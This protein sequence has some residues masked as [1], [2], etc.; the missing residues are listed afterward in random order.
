MLGA[1]A[2]RLGRR[3][4]IRRLFAVVLGLV[5]A[6][7]TAPMGAAAYTIA[8]LAS[9][10][11]NC[12]QGI[13]G[14][15]AQGDVVGLGDFASLPF[16]SEPTLGRD[17]FF[18]HDGAFTPLKVLSGG[19]TSANHITG[20]GT[21]GY[22]TANAVN[23]SGL[24]VGT[25]INRTAFPSP[26]LA[27]QWSGSG[28]SPVSLGT[29]CVPNSMQFQGSAA[30]A[31]NSAG[32]VAGQSDTQVA[33][34]G[35]YSGIRPSAGVLRRA[36]DSQ[37]SQ[38]AVAGSPVSGG[39][40]LQDGTIYGQA[41]NAHDQ[42]VVLDDN[43][44]AASATLPSA[45]LWTPTTPGGPLPGTLTAL[46]IFP[47]ALSPLGPAPPNTAP[48]NSSSMVLNDAGVV[49]GG[50]LSQVTGYTPAYSQNGGSA[51]SLT[52]ADGLPFGI[53]SAI[54]NHG[55][56]VGTSFNTSGQ[57]VATLWSG[58]GSAPGSTGTDLNTLLPKNSGWALSEG[59]GIGDGGDIVAYGSLNG[60]PGEYVELQTTGR[61][62]IQGTI[63]D[64]NGKGLPNVT[65]KLTGTDST[66]GSTVNTTAVTDATGSYL[67]QLNTGDYTV[68][69]QPPGRGRFLDV[70]CDGARTPGA[71]EV[72][73][74]AKQQAT[75]SFKY[76][77]GIVVNSTADSHNGQSSG[78]QGACDATPTEPK[79][80][81]TLRAAIE[82]SNQLGGRNIT[83]DVPG[84]GVP[85]IKVGTEVGTPLP[86][87]T[88]PTV[89]DGS[90]QPA[91]RVEVQQSLPEGGPVSPDPGLDLQSASVTVRGLDIHGFGSA[92]NIHV[93]EPGG[94]TIEQD[95]LG[96]DATGRKALWGSY[97]GI[98]LVGSGNHISRDVIS[99]N[100]FG[101]EDS[102]DAGASERNTIVQNTI[103]PT[104]G[105]TR[106]ATHALGSAN[107]A[108]DDY[109]K[110]LQLGGALD[111]V[112]A[113]G[114]GNTIAG[115]A[116]RISGVGDVVQGNTFLSSTLVAQSRSE[117]IG[118]SAASGA[119]NTFLDDSDNRIPYFRYHLILSGVDGVV[120]GNRF[121]G[122]NDDATRGVLLGGDSA[123]VG[124]DSPELGNYFQGLLSAVEVGRVEGDEFQGH[125][126]LFPTTASPAGEEIRSNHFS[127][128]TLAVVDEAS[129]GVHITDNEMQ[130]NGIGILLDT[131]YSFQ[132]V[133]RVN[134]HVTIGAN[135]IFATGTGPALSPKT[136]HPNH[137]QASP[138]LYEASRKAG[139]TVIRANMTGDG[140]HSFTIE[141]YAQHDCRSDG[142]SVG[143]GL[144][145]L[146][147][148][149]LEMGGLRT[150]DFELSFRGT[151]DGAVT[152]TATTSDGSTSEFS[153]CLRIGHKAPSFDKTG[154][155]VIDGT[156][157]VQP[158]PS[159]STSPDIPL[160]TAAKSKPKAT[161]SVAIVHV[162]C[163]PITTKVCTGT[164]TLRTVGTRHQHAIAIAKIR[165]RLAHGRIGDFTI[166]LPSN[167]AKLLSTQHRL[168]VLA[169]VTA[170]DGRRPPR[171]KR[172]SKILL[173]VPAPKARAGAKP[174]FRP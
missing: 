37:F 23:A 98:V 31:V 75:A 36:G 16:G 148:Q 57:A 124:G 42:V 153:P 167:A 74:A 64:E 125:L 49:V 13:S 7:L 70:Q 93:G 140:G 170:H 44:G 56:A 12:V 1:F 60:G 84:A 85:L 62:A 123:T 168:R 61:G 28:G 66:D 71:C 151:S 131:W 15:D 104:L 141:L 96:T 55:D 14:I 78:Q 144:Q 82:T 143:Q 77:D 38:I 110:P 154:A 166:R 107:P 106:P 10:N 142:I 161:A 115:V 155:P 97:A 89:I 121:S 41:I 4:R 91:G 173:F 103:G 120:Q 174:V 138:L 118:G 117:T 145:S 6:A 126:T 87:I 162:F 160:A 127:A 172:A 171:T 130:D 33:C 3:V 54:N 159:P 83:F 8:P 48:E 59:V 100:S 152:A 101:I 46:P 11:V 35:S 43:A 149:K 29:L 63:T 95:Y 73:L 68:T 52:T 51:V 25:A 137:D 20:C 22:T 27:V 88:A 132:E 34:N 9:A 2:V 24:I 135:S 146:G 150:K 80:T 102:N 65:V 69:P 129:N 47:F 79:I 5:V 94:D 119:G 18:W 99:G 39:G 114:Q 139:K 164:L 156:I 113:P 86:A 40:A 30:Y 76:A 32:D 133:S 92:G 58:T 45:Y 17:G 116:A 72:A 134:G 50:E 122:P 53:A 19:W 169:T 67:F 157:Q 165:F 158:G 136:V 147:T 81:C 163:P 108:F 128:D 111:T 26:S 105:E 90:T 109:E 21:A 112:G